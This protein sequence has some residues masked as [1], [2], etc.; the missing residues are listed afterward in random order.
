MK[1]RSLLLGALLALVA[2]LVVAG[3]AAAAV[4]KVDK[5][6]DK[7]GA[8]PKSG[9]CKTSKA[10]KRTKKNKGKA[11]KPDCTLRAAIQAANAK[12]GKDRLVLKKKNYRLKIMGTGEDGAKT[13]DLDVTSEIEITGRNGSVNGKGIDRIFESAPRAI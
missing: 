11:T 7:V 1:N 4:F 12:P 9:K 8:N 13:G 5:R 3:P 6:A 2:M 10:S